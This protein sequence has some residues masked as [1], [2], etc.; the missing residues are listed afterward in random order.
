[1]DFLLQHHSVFTLVM[2]AGVAT[3]AGIIKGM[4][5]FGMPMVLISGLS[6]VLAPEVALAGLIFPTLFSNGYQAFRHGPRAVINSVKKFRVFLIAGGIAMVISAQFVLMVAPETL[7]LLIGI[8]VAF[9]AA[10]QLF[11]LSIRIAKPSREG[12][13]AVG[14]V[15]GAIGGV[16]GVWG[17]PT[18]T[19][20][21]ALGTP[22][23]EQM[24][25]QGVIYG[26]GAV[27]LVFAHI[28]S[29]VLRPD[30]APLSFFLVLPAMIGMWIGT[31]ISDHIDQAGFRRAT[32]LV[33]LIAALNLIRR[34]LFG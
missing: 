25:V 5:G 12:E 8:P 27:V 14:V 6:S 32:L 1:M 20:L 16:S 10:T 26:L 18:V 4:V 15:A 28:G 7:L 2:A 21:T 11:G 34:A 22:K 23:A 30:T 19:Y 9:F 17:P 3:L 33:L 24:R 31:R 29:G 13:I